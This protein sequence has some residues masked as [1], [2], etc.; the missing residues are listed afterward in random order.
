[1]AVTR[2][3]LDDLLKAID[4]L[5]EGIAP[6]KDVGKP[7]LPVDRV[8]TIS[9]FGTVV[10]GTLVD[11]QL[12]TGQEMEILPV[13]TRSRIRGLQTHKKKVETAT[14]GSR[15]A[16][17]LVGVSTE[18]VKRGLVVTTPGWLKPTGAVDVKLRILKTV[19][20]PLKHNAHVAF[21]HGADEVAATVRLLDKNE[22][23]AG[24][25]G[26]AQVVVESP[27][28]VVKGEPFVIRSPNETL[29]GGYVIDTHARRHRRFRD[30]VSLV[31]E[32]LDTESPGDIVTATIHSNEFIDVGTLINKTNLPLSQVEELIETLAAEKKLFVLAGRGSQAVLVTDDG[33]QKKGGTAVAAVGNFHV[34]YPLRRGM[35]REELRSRLKIASQPFDGFISRLVQ[36]GL[37]VEKRNII[38]LP[39]FNVVLSP[40]QEKDA[41]VFLQSLADSPY[42]PP[43]GFVPEPELLNCLIDEGK[44]VKVSGDIFFS[45]AAYDEM[46]GGIIEKIKAEGKITLGEVRD[47]FSTSRKYAQGIIEHLDEQKITR[48]VGDERVLRDSSPRD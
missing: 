9:G 13:G 16:V 33:Y 29:G 12:N 19:S 28:A 18:Q 42:A 17:N 23:A 46:V 7:R 3:G 36:D 14:P 4:R 39:S 30:E 26:W 5:I 48:R 11:G 34:Q 43:S 38:S 45:R 41:G 47:M 35:A 37:L 44:V 40:Q 22:L 25:T 2:E 6:K 32:G 8:F 10:T 20:K 27:V 24:E 21:F 1:S 31:L 15:V